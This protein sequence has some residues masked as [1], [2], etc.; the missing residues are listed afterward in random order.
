MD[1]AIT[2]TTPIVT[3]IYTVHKANTMQLSA[4]TRRR[5]RAT[6]CVTPVVLYTR[7]LTFVVTVVVELNRQQFRRAV[8]KFF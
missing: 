1:T 2:A 8:E 3:T 6:R 4:I 7:G 5:T